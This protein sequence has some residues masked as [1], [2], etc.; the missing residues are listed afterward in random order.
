MKISEQILTLSKQKKIILL[1]LSLTFVISLY[2]YLKVNHYHDG[3][4]YS[5]LN[6]FGNSYLQ[7]NYNING[8]EILIDNSLT[9]SS[10]IECEQYEDRIEFID[11]NNS[12]KILYAL[13][14]GDLEL[15]KEITLK[16]ITSD[17]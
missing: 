15:S 17:K 4:Y 3:E 14:N 7:I 8:N 1:L 12:T 13:E 11:E 9:G 10:K 16:K 5:S 6:G 2:P